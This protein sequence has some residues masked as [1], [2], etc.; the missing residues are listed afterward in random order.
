M[1][2]LVVLA[3]L[4]LI[5]ASPVR[6]VDGPRLLAADPAPLLSAYGLF[7][8]SAGRVPAAGVVRYT[9]NTPLF[10]DYAE[11]FRYVWMPAGTR[12]TYTPK[13]VLEFPVGTA[14]VKNFAY[15][16][17]FRSPDA[18]L[19]LIETR[20]LVRRTDGWVPLSYVWNDGQTDAVLRRAGVRVPVSFIDAHG[21][22]GSIDYAVPNVNQCKQCHL[23]G[24][25][26][27]PIGPTAGNLNGGLEGRGDN[28]LITWAAADRLAGLPANP[29]KQ[30]GRA[31]V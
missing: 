17:D 22:A 16:A 6:E 4:L 5:G 25:A 1:Q 27:T 20:L 15:P 26:V 9:L 13:G 29:P 18:K 19:R 23:Q 24:S 31:H 11:K 3:A 8:D 12:A 21:A 10:S 28:Q 14:I 30:I 7:A 2:R